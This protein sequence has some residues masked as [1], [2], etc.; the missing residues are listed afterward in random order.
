MRFDFSGIV[1]EREGMAKIAEP[2]ST[3][4]EFIIRRDDW[5]IRD[6]AAAQNLL[7]QLPGQKNTN[8]VL[9]LHPAPEYLK[10]L[11]RPLI[12]SING[13]YCVVH[14]AGADS[15]WLMGRDRAVFEIPLSRFAGFYRWN[16]AVRYRKNAPEQMYRMADTGERVRWIQSVLKSAGHMKMKPN[17][18]FGVETAAGIE[19]LQEAYGLNR[20]GVV[21]ADTL[22]LLGVIGGGKP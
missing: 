9:N 6:Y 17:G 5:T 8:A 22:A 11:G 3:K 15:V 19:K 16:V 1:G 20:D 4:R 12:A 10:D 14:H 13:G 21:G 2:P 18:V 7:L